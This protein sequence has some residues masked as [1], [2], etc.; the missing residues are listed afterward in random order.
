MPNVLRENW[1]VLMM[2]VVLACAAGIIAA[3]AWRLRRRTEAERQDSA[4]RRVNRDIEAAK[5][6]HEWH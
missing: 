4:L 5:R 2:A 1:P 6:A 3:D